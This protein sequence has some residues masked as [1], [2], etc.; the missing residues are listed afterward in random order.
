MPL[1]SKIKDLDQKFAWSFLGVLLAVVFGTFTI[2]KEF[3]QDQHPGLRYDIL[4]STS[5]LDVKEEVSNLSVLFDGMDI[6][7]QGL[8][9]RVITIRILNDSAKD[10]LKGFYDD[11]APLG[12]SL[13]TGKIIRS[14]L[15]GASND[16]LAQNVVLSAPDDKSLLFPNLII[17]GGQSFSLKLLVLHPKNEV[18]TVRPLGKIAGIQSIPVH[19]A[20]KEDTEES[21]LKKSFR[22][23][24]LLQAVRFPAYTVA[25][26]LLLIFVIAPIAFIADKLEGRKRRGHVE[27]Y[28]AV[29]KQDLNVSDEYVFSQYV[30]RGAGALILM[31]SLLS[32]EK[33]LQAAY[34]RYREREHVETAE[35]DAIRMVYYEHERAVGMWDNPFRLHDY[36]IAG[37]VKETGGGVVSDAHVMLTLQDFL[38]YLRNKGILSQKEGPSS[39][40]TGGTE[41]IVDT[42]EKPPDVSLNSNHP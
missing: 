40:P 36:I 33:R 20:Y 18:P 30:E 17:E 11:K 35:M 38:R 6:R 21:F 27:A 12:L 26:I 15:A 32:N 13:S 37:I 2:Y 22:G 16:Y 9:L 28:R 31:N 10:I 34:K 8:S 14:E 41:I 1:M 25:T 39:T 29:R 23:G 5:V 4:T 24:F 42:S 7:K 3:V 19:E